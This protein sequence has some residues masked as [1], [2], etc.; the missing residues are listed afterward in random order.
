[1]KTRKTAKIK[2]FDELRES[3]EGAL[4]FE[5]GEPLD[6]RVTE[7]PSAPTKMRPREIKKIRESLN[8]SQVLFA[9]FLNVSPNTVRSWEQ[10]TR[11]PQGADLKLLS[12][13]KNNPQALLSA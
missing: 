11:R 5:R 12:I 13:A 7:L 9:R 4:A 8:A 6:L 10:G 3:L 2:V 1:M